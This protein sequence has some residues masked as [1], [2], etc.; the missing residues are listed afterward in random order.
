MQ[1]TVPAYASAGAAARNRPVCM[2]FTDRTTAARCEFYL[3]CAVIG[4]FFSFVAASVPC[5][6][7]AGFLI[8]EESALPAH[9]HPFN[10]AEGVARV[11]V[12]REHLAA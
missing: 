3:A 4:G 7:D 10:R 5:V 11:C 8:G 2:C 12:S 6:Y 1:C 9:P